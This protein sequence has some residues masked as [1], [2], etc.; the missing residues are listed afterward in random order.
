[1]TFEPSE[2][3]IYRQPFG[4][5]RDFCHG[6]RLHAELLTFLLVLFA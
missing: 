1:V 2:E 4:D 5:L 3:L 6:F